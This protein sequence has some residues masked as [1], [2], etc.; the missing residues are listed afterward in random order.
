MIGTVKH[1]KI[2]YLILYWKTVKTIRPIS[3][4]GSGWIPAIL[5]SKAEY[6]FLV[7]HQKE[8]NK[9]KNYW[10]GGSSRAKGNIPFSYYLSYDKGSGEMLFPTKVWCLLIFMPYTATRI[11]KKSLFVQIFIQYL[12]L[13]KNLS[14][15]IME[16]CSLSQV[17]MIWNYMVFFVKMVCTFLLQ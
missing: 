16:T 7:G 6:D 15:R 3:E 2:R 1:N 10:I 12:Y 5:T 8:L 4:I 17:Q 9:Y 14:P 11:S 13:H